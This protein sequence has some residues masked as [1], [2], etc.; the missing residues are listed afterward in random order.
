[1]NG[2]KPS[3]SLPVA[4]EA[5]P[6]GR[7]A[8]RSPRKKRSPFFKLSQEALEAG[9]RRMAAVILEVLAG[10]RTPTEAAGALGVSPP[11]YY[12]LEQ[13]AILGLVEAC[14]SRKRG[15]ARSIA[16]EVEKLRS[17]VK[18][19]ERECRRTQALLRVAHR[20]ANLPPV[21]PRGPK[22]SGKRRR[23]RPTAR[24]L[25]A[26]KA[27]GG[28]SLEGKSAQPDDGRGPTT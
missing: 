19:Q 10:V 25:K 5:R 13:R 9:A 23:R 11:R 22:V 7:E 3:P 14:R 27:L 4:P 8:E 18:R 26:A 21:E 6:A 1:M 28:N 24:A 16:N 15:P 2:I 20:T 12:A 17:E